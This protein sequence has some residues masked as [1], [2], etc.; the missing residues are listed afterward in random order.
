MCRTLAEAL[1]YVP[2][3]QCAGVSATCPRDPH[4]RA[5]QLV[6]VNE[7]EW[8]PN[9]W[10]LVNSVFL[11]HSR[12]FDWKEV[13]TRHSGVGNVVTHRIVFHK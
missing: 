6:G 4:L 7:V 11:F 5:D 3:S 9:N 8:W 2:A 13:R 12:R 10:G 1:Q